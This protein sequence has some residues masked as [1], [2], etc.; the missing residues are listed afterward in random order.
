MG[1]TFEYGK[2]PISAL[3]VEM[4]VGKKG[5]A[6]A[7]WLH[8]NGEKIAPTKR[9]WTSLKMRFRF[10]TN[11]FRYFAHHEVFERITKVAPND[12]I[13]WCIERIDG[14]TQR[15]LGVSNPLN[16]IIPYKNLCEILLDRNPAGINYTDGFVRS[17]HT[18]KMP[19][20][21]EIAGDQFANQFVLDC[22]IDG[23]GKPAVYLSMLRQVCSN[24]MIGYSR[25]FRSEVALGRKEDSV[26]HTLCRVLDSFN[27]E[28]GYAALKQRTEAATRSWA[29]LK[30][31][32]DLRNTVLR[33][34]NAGDLKGVKKLVISGNPDSVADYKDIKPLN[35][36]LGI[37]SKLEKRYGLVNLDAMSGKKQRTLP[38][39]CTVYQLLNMASELATHNATPKGSRDLQAFI[40]TK[41]S[42]EYDIENSCD[43]YHDWEDFFVQD[44]AAA[45]ALTSVQHGRDEVTI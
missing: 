27:N 43:I 12:Q 7:K 14:Q 41:L 37:T 31:V 3:Q 16:P 19:Y 26:E 18:P 20:K 15:M 33:V 23:F 13:R 11:I 38:G 22:P 21:F 32:Q 17:T 40:G 45:A 34:Y 10:N 4:G 1:V 28:D 2:S 25:E 30:E 35:A 8:F 9:F 44:N 39:G 24:G 36:L 29:S 42:D 5:K 6:I